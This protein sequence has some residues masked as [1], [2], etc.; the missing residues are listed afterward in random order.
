LPKSVNVSA[1][2][3]CD[4]IEAFWPPARKI[5]YMYLLYNIFLI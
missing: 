3:G 1:I 5:R 2:L 4:Y